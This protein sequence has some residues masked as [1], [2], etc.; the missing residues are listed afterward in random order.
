MEM[1]RLSQLRAVPLVL[2]AV[3]LVA[4]EPPAPTASNGPTPSTHQPIPGIRSLSVAVEQAAAQLHAGGLVVAEVRDGTV[5]YFSAGKPAPRA[6][7]PPEKV[8]FEI[9]SVTKVFTGLLLAQ[10]VVEH[11]VALNDPI[12]RYLPPNVATSAGLT[13][14]TLEQLATHTS[15]LP[16]L[17]YNMKPPS[18]DD[19]YADYTVE[20]LYAFLRAYSPKRPPPRP[21]DYSNLGVGLLGHL[22]SRVYGQSYAELVG[23]KITGP[24]GMADTVVN[25]NDEQRSRFAVPHEDRK[26]IQAWDI[27]TLAGAGALHS[28]ALDL[29]RFTQVLMSSAA[30]P[31]RAA[32]DIVRQPRHD[33]PWNRLETGLIVTIEKRD[34]SADYSHNGRTGGFRSY[35]E[36]SPQSGGAVVILENNTTVERK[37]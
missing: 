34:G 29:A 13:G 16:R 17:P 3:W 22:L 12:A 26:I 4:D 8:I 11:K 33:I 19:P 18:P 1:P 32:W 5:R 36:W 37:R 7:I 6:G 9:G 21:W 2:T 23:A 10:A 20:E 25:L 28:T 35:L 27:P 31:L 24:L 15:G 30:N 14:I